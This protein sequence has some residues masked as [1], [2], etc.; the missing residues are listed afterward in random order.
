M[1]TEERLS[2]IERLKVG[3]GVFNMLRLTDGPGREVRLTREGGTTFYDYDSDGNTTFGRGIPAAQACIWGLSN[4]LAQLPRFVGRITDDR[5]GS[6][7]RVQHPLNRL[8][9]R[10]SDWIDPWQ[11]WLAFFRSL[12]VSGNAFAKI[13][14]DTAGLF[15]VGLTPVVSYGNVRRLNGKREYPCVLAYANGKIVREWVE[16]DDLL[17]MHWPC[18]DYKTGV[19]MSPVQYMAVIKMMRSGIRAQMRVADN[20]PSGLNALKID[21]DELPS[22]EPKAKKL[23]RKVRKAMAAARYTDRI[24]TLYSGM[25]I[26]QLNSMSSE[27]MA[28]IESL[29][30]GTKSMA[31]AYEYPLRR[32]QHFEQGVKQREL[33]AQRD[34]FVSISINPHAL[35]FES[36]AS[37]KLLP[38]PLRKNRVMMPA[39][40]L[41]LGTVKE[42]VEQAV[43]IANFG[44]LYENE[45]RAAGNYP[46]VPG[47]DER[48][49]SSRGTNPGDNPDANQNQEGDDTGAEQ[50]GGFAENLV[51]GGAPDWARRNIC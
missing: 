15:P 25:D 17:A 22:G 5:Y 30:L 31:Q 18:M 44:A 19:S 40:R 36:Q 35:A 21:P 45:L 46:P 49:L 39:D 42:R 26:K 38:Q 47:G 32:L 14:R 27:D 23:L 29:N 51:N 8:F 20:A 48:K 3:Y 12:F 28:I 37:F 4:S 9:D 7:E 24:F 1:Q 34:D 50:E 6:H 16:Y 33:A 41:R 43:Q 2:F 13:E 10:P 11:F